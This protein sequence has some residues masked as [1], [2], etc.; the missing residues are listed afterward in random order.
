MNIQSFDYSVNLLRSL[1]WAHNNSVNLQ[2]LLQAKQDWYNQN[3]VDF[4]EDWIT[5]VFDLRTANEFGLSVWS[6]I[7]N[8]PLFGDNNV[9][10][11]SYPAFNFE[12]TGLNFEHGNFATDAV[13]AFGL[14]LEQ[15]RV[16]LR[17]RYFQLI[18]R[19]STPEINQFLN[20]LFGPNQMYVLDGLNM[21]MTYVFVGADARGFFS[22]FQLFDI[23]PRPAGVEVNFIDSDL[24]FFGFGQFNLNFSNGSFAKQ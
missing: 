16:L 23:L 15:K 1:L 11:P 21:T 9:S 20:A 18:T 13:G 14:P 12:P 22:L 4:W 10:P 24:E 7:L 6:S 5:N 19:G 17:L 2:A 3:H 8:F